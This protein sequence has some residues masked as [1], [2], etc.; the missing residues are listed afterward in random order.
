LPRR[1][2]RSRAEAHWVKEAEAGT[3]TAA[4]MAADM[5]TAVATE[6]AAETDMAQVELEA[7]RPAVGELVEAKS[8]V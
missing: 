4:G 5:G 2:A 6:V 3:E 8:G 1:R 7:L